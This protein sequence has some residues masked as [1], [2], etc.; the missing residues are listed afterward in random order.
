MVPVAATPEAI[1]HVN[2]SWLERHLR[3]SRDLTPHIIDVTA[4][5]THANSAASRPLPASTTVGLY[6]S[7]V[8]CRSDGSD[9]F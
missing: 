9:P 6:V 5:P 2:S 3:T 4:M 7:V 1:Q 8:H